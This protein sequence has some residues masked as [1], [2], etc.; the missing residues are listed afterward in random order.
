[1]EGVL[2]APVAAD[3]GG[4][5]GGGKRRGGDVEAL[6]AGGFA[7]LLDGGLDADEGGELGEAVLA[8]VTAVGEQPIDLVG[9]ADPSGLDAAMVLV[10]VE[11]GVEG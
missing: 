1:M 2:D 8:G 5:A 4:G 6:F 7:G 10:D 11:G 9:D 3:G